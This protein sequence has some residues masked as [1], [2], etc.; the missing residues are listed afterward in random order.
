MEDLFKIEKIDGK[1]LG[2][3]ALRD[4]KAGTLIYKEKDKNLPNPQ[5][6]D[7]Y[8]PHFE[9]SLMS[10]FFALSKNDQKE[11]LERKNKYLDL[12]S[13]PD[14]SKKWFFDLKQKIQCLN[15]SDG[16]LLLKI[17]CIHVSN[18]LWFRGLLGVKSARINHSCCSNSFVY[19]NEMTSE[20]EIRATSKIRYFFKIYNYM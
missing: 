6:I 19:V 4:I 1:G 15:R 18:G 3:I 2:W 11:F 16:E 12:N 13:L 14:Y 8:P 7:A 17:I 5:D 10:A 9:A 20:S